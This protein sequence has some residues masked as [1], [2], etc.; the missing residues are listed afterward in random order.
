MARGLNLAVIAEG[1]ET[2]EQLVFLQMHACHAVQGYL[3]SRPLPPD[4]MAELLRRGV[5]AE[6]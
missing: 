3:Y 2:R 1:V 4:R 5:K 6:G